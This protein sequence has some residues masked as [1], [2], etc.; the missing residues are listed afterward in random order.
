MSAGWA[1]KYARVWARSL[2]SFGQRVCEANERVSV[3]EQSRDLA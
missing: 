2:P 1:L 3:T